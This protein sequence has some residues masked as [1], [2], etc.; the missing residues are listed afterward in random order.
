MAP[1]KAALLSVPGTG[2]HTPRAA[3][4]DHILKNTTGYT[5][6]VFE[7]KTEQAA[8]VQTL[9]KGKGFIPPDLVD[10]EVQWFYL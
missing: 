6:T 9:L 3:T 5:D 7:G 1:V 8:A 4:P 2:T 10:A